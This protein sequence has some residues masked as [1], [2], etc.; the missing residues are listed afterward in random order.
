MVAAGW[1][2]LEQLL[3]VDCQAVC[4]L[5]E[6]GFRPKSVAAAAH[7]VIR[8]AICDPRTHR[9]RDGVDRPA[10][11][12]WRRP[13]LCYRPTDFVVGSWVH[14]RANEGDP[15]WLGRV[16]AVRPGLAGPDHVLQH[17]QR[18]CRQ[19]FMVDGDG[20][21]V[22]RTAQ[23]REWT[24]MLVRSV[25]YFP[26]EGCELGGGSRQCAL[27]VY[28]DALQVARVWTEPEFAQVV[29]STRRRL[30]PLPY[31][32]DLEPD[33]KRA[34]RAGAL[35]DARVPR[36]EAPGGPTGA[37]APVSC[38]QWSGPPDLVTTTRAVMRQW[39]DGAGERLYSDGSVRGARMALGVVAPGAGGVA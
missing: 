7:G 21:D 27:E 11:H 38:L 32:L 15:L 33:E 28:G 34:V 24:R 31:V 3:T 5:A 2:Y 39:R 23:Y 30:I 8:R 29:P 17:Y 13:P 12:P 9:L 6:L 22:R 10:T 35:R 20:P 37:V 18:A 36:A 1:R 4:T 14:W 25:V 16:Q 19:D 26:C